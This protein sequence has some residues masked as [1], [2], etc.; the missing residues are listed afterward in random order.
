M[1]NLWAP[2][3]MSY[4]KKE[5]NR[6]ADS[7]LFCPIIAEA[8]DERDLVAHRAPLSIAL[9]NK[10]PYNTGHSLILPRR[11]LAELDELEPDEMLELME[12]VR[13]CL[14]ALR[15]V[16]KPNGFNLGLNL[17]KIAGAGI[18]GHLHF[19]LVPRW[20]GDHN[21]MAVTA[22]TRVLPEMLPVTREKIANAIVQ[23]LAGK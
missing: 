18:P 2:W 11:H 16:L 7:C 1:E 23:I 22:D 6:P 5:A 14:R 19:H 21:F 12:T 3:R 17:G 13:L 10:Y 15:R 4:I 20:D 9:L 8:E